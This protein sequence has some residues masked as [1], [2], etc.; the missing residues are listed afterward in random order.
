[1]IIKILYRPAEVVEGQWQTIKETRKIREAR[2]ELASWQGPSLSHGDLVM[3]AARKQTLFVFDAKKSAFVEV[4]LAPVGGWQMFWEG[5]DSRSDLMLRAC[6]KDG[7]SVDRRRL[8]LAACRLAAPALKTIVW[9]WRNPRGIDLDMVEA[10]EKAIDKAIAWCFGEASVAE[11][12][13]A[14]DALHLPGGDPAFANSMAAIQRATEVPFIDRPYNT[15]CFSAAMAAEF[16]AV[17]D[18][19]FGMIGRRDLSREERQESVERALRSNAEIVRRYIPLSVFA[20]AAVGARD[21]LPIP[22]YEPP[23]PRYNPSR[24]R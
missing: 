16:Q 9:E 23:P 14:R 21:P 3:L 7:R 20:C 1:M 18:I 17:G 19:Q 2:D 10:A 13:R 24:P 5:D 11:V 8:T 12:E 6:C 15:P 22:R 4:R